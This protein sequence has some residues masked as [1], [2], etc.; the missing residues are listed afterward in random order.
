MYVGI[1][2]KLHDSQEIY[3]RDHLFNYSIPYGLV[4]HLKT[5]FEMDK[6]TK[7]NCNQYCRIRRKKLSFFLFL[8]FKK[9]SNRRLRKKVFKNYFFLLI[10]G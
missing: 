8:A 6:W 7:Q 5:N 2:K 10:L 3:C 9:E 4:F 1:L